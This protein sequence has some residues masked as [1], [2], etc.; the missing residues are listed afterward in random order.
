MFWILCLYFVFWLYLRNNFF[1][2]WFFQCFLF[3]P[4]LTLFFVVRKSLELNRLK[5]QI[6]ESGR[7]SRFEIPIRLSFESHFES[8]HS[9]RKHLNVGLPI[10]KLQIT[11]KSGQIR[12]VQSNKDPSGCVRIRTSMSEFD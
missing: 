6:E 3:E 9:A 1:F 12:R 2:V 4:V 7:L 11:P 8:I 5:S 10:M